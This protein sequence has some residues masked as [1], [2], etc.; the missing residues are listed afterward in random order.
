M[1]ITKRGFIE[2]FRGNYYSGLGVIQISGEVINCENAQTVRSL[3]GCFGGIIGPQ[4]TAS[5]PDH[6]R[7]REVVYSVDDM[8]I[9]LGFTP[10]EEWTGP[11]I[12]PEGI[13]EPSTA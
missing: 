4:H 10:I 9:L 12:P 1:P 3:E 6:V 7:S 8:G 5:I 13:E 11:E 2:D